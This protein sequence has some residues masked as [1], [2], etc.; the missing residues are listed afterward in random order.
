METGKR[1]RILHAAVLLS[2]MACAEKPRPGTEP[3]GIACGPPEITGRL[4]SELREASGI[5]SSALHPGVIWV[6]VDGGGPVLTAI[7]STGRIIA[8]IEVAGAGNTDWES[9]AVAPCGQQS[10]L[11]IGDIG[12]NLRARES[13]RI[14][15]VAEPGLADRTT[16][17]ADRFAF[18]YPD[19]AHDAEAVFILPDEL[20]Y[21]I[22]KGRSEP[23]SVYRAPAP[24][25]SD[26]VTTLRLVQPLS[27]SFVQLPDMITGAGA[28]ADGQWVVL[29][30]YA[31]VQLY[32]MVEGSMQPQLPG[33]GIEL[34]ALKESQGEGA[35]LRADGTI[36][37]LSEKGLGDGPAPLSR[38]RCSLTS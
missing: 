30:T 35:D 32:R 26:S 29:R 27:A 21:V 1:F 6:V 8:R 19:G 9:L 18:R 17:P 25:T 14:Y 13:I 34:E 5:A 31:S 3:P 37:L 28:T 36:L 33:R 24:L 12:D 4:P 38:V 2:L 16:A 15:R 11:Y 23:I 10:C 20:P 7:D 22:T